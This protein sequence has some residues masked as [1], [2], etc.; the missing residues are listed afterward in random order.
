MKLLDTSALIDSLR[1]GEYV[2]GAI[3]IITLI[4]VL[5]GVDENKRYRLKQLLEKSFTVINIDNDIILKYCELYT[6][7]KRRGQLIPD[8]VLLIAAT[9]MSNNLVLVTRDKDFEGL[10][11]L[12]L[13]LQL[14]E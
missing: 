1:M 7:L 5:R 3:S 2:E 14:I 8:A 12:G 9:A 4:G 11:E 6:V 10:R 13:R